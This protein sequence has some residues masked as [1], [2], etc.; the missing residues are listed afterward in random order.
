MSAMYHF[1]DIA[2]IVALQVPSGA[3]ETPWWQ[4]VTGIIA[5][6][7][8]LLGLLYTY[9]SSQKTRLESRKLQLEILEKEGK[10]PEGEGAYS[11]PRYQDIIESP[12]AVAASLQDFVTRFIVFFIALVGAEL[13]GSLISPFWDYMLYLWG[14]PALDTTFGEWSDITP[15]TLDFLST[16]APTIAQWVV[17]LLLGLP[18]L[19]DILRTAGLP[20]LFSRS[21]KSGSRE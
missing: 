18:L 12:R 3:G 14:E 4:V 10:T 9:R 8:G 13:L 7:A 11:I 20:P 21:R 6:P 17:V 19:L 5:I 1:L 16:M 15:V 2:D